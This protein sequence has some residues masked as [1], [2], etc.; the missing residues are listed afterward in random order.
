MY[1]VVGSLAPRARAQGAPVGLTTGFATPEALY[2]GASTPSGVIWL[3]NTGFTSTVTPIFTGPL[4]SFGPTTLFNIPNAS[5]LP[6]G[7]Y[8]WF[9]LVTGSTQ[10]LCCDERYMSPHSRR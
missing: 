6:S 10:R 1:K 9:I 8:Q 2:L 7:S 4:A 3:T 5:V